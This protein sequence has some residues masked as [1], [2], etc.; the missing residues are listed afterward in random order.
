MVDNI[1]FT[2]PRF[3]NWPRP[4]KFRKD[5]DNAA[6]AAVTLRSISLFLTRPFDSISKF[7]QNLTGF[8][9]Y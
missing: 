8:P 1:E 3:P 4:E 9:L 6:V 5:R 7:D 2:S